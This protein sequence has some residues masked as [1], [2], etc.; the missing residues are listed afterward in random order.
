MQLAEERVRED[1]GKRE[2]SVDDV[3]EKR[4]ADVI[5]DRLLSFVKLDLVRLITEDLANLRGESAR[6]LRF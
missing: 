1:L 3:V 5:V 6:F 4:D 2:P